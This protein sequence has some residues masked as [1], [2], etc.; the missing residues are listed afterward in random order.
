MSTK[1]LVSSLKKHTTYLEESRGQ[2]YNYIKDLLDYLRP[3][4]KNKLRLKTVATKGIR[5]TEP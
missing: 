5:G 4:T 2:V 3:L 1:H